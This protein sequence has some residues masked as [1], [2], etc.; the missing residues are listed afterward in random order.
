MTGKQKEPL[1]GLATTRELLQDLKARGEVSMPW[2]TDGKYVSKLA[3]LM[4]DTLSDRSLDYKTVGTSS[5]PTECY[6]Q[7]CGTV[8]EYGG[9]CPPEPGSQ[10]G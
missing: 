6:H 7:R 9:D 5:G 4:L 8:H 1:L 3:G 10:I 2:D